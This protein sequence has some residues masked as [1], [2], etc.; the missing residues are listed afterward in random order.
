MIDVR[1]I[2]EAE[3]DAF[4][5]LLE[6]AFGGD[7]EPDE[8]AMWRPLVEADRTHG[9]FDGATLVGSAAV[10]TF[11][12][13]VPGGPLPCAGVTGVSVAPTHRRQGVLTAMMRAQLDAVRDRGTEPFASLWASEPVIYHR[14]G[15]G[16][17]SRRWQYTVNAHDPGLL[18]RDPGGSIRLVPIDEARD[19]APPV[20][21]AARRGRPG[22]I[23]RSPER[24]QT[25]ISDLPGHRNGASSQ[26]NAVYE[27]DGEVRGYAWYR[28]KGDWT[29]G[30]PTGQVRLKELVALDADAHGAL[31]RFLLGIDLMRSVH[32]DNAPG[33]DPIAARLRDQRTLRVHAMDGLY[34]RVLDVAAALAGR[35]YATSGTVTVEVVDDWGYAAGRWTLDA[36]PEGAKCEASTDT[37]DLTLSAEELGAA[38]LGETSLR[39]LHRA[40]RVDEH[41]PGAVDRASALLAWPVAPWCPEIF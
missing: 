17:A 23:S 28:T 26:K 33:D 13:T 30:R 6:S 38:Y 37:A 20:Y 40:A 21:D 22:M 2:A 3:V 18:G 39:T 9:A 41:T 32:W 7:P 11:D 12:M 35:A 25:R 5:H 31:W 36:S 4:Q 14:F 15:Y 8:L 24:W 16:V 10:F 34:V 27:R 29:E 19:L 1:I